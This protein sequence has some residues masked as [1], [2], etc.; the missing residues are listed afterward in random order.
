MHCEKSWHDLIW[1]ISRKQK[2]YLVF[3]VLSSDDDP[4]RSMQILRLDMILMLFDLMCVYVY[5][6]MFCG[7]IGHDFKVLSNIILGTVAF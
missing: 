6:S 5:I 2:E 1:E 3:A 7:L 4:M